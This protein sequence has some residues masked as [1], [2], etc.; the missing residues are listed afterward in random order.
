MKSTI[1]MFRNEGFYYIVLKE[2]E[3]IFADGK[4]LEGYNS[5]RIIFNLKTKTVKSNII[6]SSNQKRLNYLIEHFKKELNWK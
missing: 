3:I 2:N 6:F 4:N 1:E 5:S